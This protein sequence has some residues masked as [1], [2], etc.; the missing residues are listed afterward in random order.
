MADGRGRNV[1]AVDYDPFAGGALARVVPTTEPQRELWLAAQL[2]EDAS[3]AYNESVSLQL[4]GP[5][6]V[7]RLQRALQLV[8]DRHDALRASFGP[9][10]ETFCVLEPAPLPLEVVDLSQLPQAGREAALAQR[11]RAGV[12][13]AFALAQGRLFRA[14]LL[15]LS[16]QEH[17]LLMH[18][19][20]IVCDGWSWWVLVREL[21]T[22]YARGD[23]PLPRCR[24]PSFADYALA[25]AMRPVRRGAS[26]TSSTGCPGSPAFRRC[27]TS[28]DWP[29]PAARTPRGAGLR[30]RRRARVRGAAHGARRGASLFATLLGAFATLMSRVAGQSEVVVGIPAA[31]QSVDGHEHLVGHC[32]NLLPLKFE[33]APE[34][35]SPTCSMARRP[36]C[37]T[38]SNTS[39][40]FGTLLKKLHMARAHACRWSA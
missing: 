9:D 19:H 23:G 2:G 11:R 18:A 32:V 3:L 1:S 25:E 8:V 24:R 31:G 17:V 22:A 12:E 7:A 26:R 37:W 21:G 27:S 16:P 15:K 36:C 20:H 28:T 40:T 35:A 13:T 39:A 5:L 38:R 6:D 29:R 10:G 33:L 34:Q 30:A 4:R 14:E